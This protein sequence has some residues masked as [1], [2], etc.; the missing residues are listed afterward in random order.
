MKHSEKLD[1]LPIALVKFHRLMKGIVKDKVNT[2]FKSSYVTLDTIIETITPILTDCELSVIQD[3]STPHTDTDGQLTAITVETFLLHSSGEWIM[4]SVVIPVGTV[5]VKDA[6]GEVVGAAPTAQTAGASLTYGRR[7]GLTALLTLTSDEDDD[8]NRASERSAP[9]RTTVRRDPQPMTRGATSNRVVGA[10]TTLP[11]WPDYEFAGQEIK[12]V[13][14]EALTKIMDWTPPPAKAEAYQPLKD[15]VARE[16]EHR[17]T[18]QGDLL[19]TP[20]PGAV[21]KE[22]EE[23][24][25]LEPDDDLPF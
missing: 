16:L 25:D 4:A 22:W 21:G 23:K 18:A 5:P 2:F 6:A 11:K 12:K 10:I 15:A 7:Y 9:A 8:G 13:P 20:A 3:G 14:V 1:N 17:R 24:P 19:K